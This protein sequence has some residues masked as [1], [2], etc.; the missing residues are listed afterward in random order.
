MRLSSPQCTMAS[1]R[2]S[3]SSIK[4]MDFYKALFWIGIV[5][6]IGS[7]VT[8]LGGG[9]RDH[10]LVALGGTAAVFVGSKIGREVLGL[11]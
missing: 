8:M 6:L 10:A 1:A 9:M 5:V 11:A 2:F 7:H 4:D 3:L